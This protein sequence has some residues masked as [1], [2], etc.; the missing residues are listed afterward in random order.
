MVRQRAPVAM[1]SPSNGDRLAGVQGQLAGTQVHGG[2]PQ[3]EAGL[4]AVVGQFLGVGQR[5]PLGL[6][7][8]RQHL[9]GQRRPVIGKVLLGADER[10]RPVETLPAQGLGRV[11]AGQ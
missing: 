8:A 11:Q 10:D 9:L 3:A 7:V 5:G 2:G 6:P 1:T 4:D